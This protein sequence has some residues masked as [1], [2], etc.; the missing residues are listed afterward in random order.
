MYICIYIHIYI[1]CIYGQASLLDTH[2]EGMHICIYVYMYVYC[3][4]GKAS[5]PDIYLWGMYI[6]IYV[7]IYVFC[8]YLYRANDVR[9][10]DVFVVR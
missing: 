8:I 7:Y 3:I 10:S 2:M 6:C 1:Y 4:Y 5:L 9:V